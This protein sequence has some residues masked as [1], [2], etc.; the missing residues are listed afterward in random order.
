VSTKV[1]ERRYKPIQEM[2]EAQVR[3]RVAACHLN[4]S[5][6]LETSVFSLT[7]RGA[8]RRANFHV[9]KALAKGSGA[10]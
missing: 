10:D 5:H 8:A 9:K 4:W 2:A 1:A 7:Y 6:D 3:S